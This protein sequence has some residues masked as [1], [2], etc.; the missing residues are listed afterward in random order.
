MPPLV[1]NFLNWSELGPKAQKEA[2]SRPSQRRDQSVIDTVAKIFDDL[3]REGLA[4]LNRWASRLDRHPYQRLDLDDSAVNKARSNLSYEALN[5]LELAHHNIKA[6]HEAELPMI[7]PVLS[8]ISGLKLQRHF[9]PIQTAGLY[10]PG[11]SAPLFSTLM[12]SALPALIA[13]VPNRVAITPPDQSGSLPAI[14]IAAAGLCG[15]KTIH[16]VGGAH[17]IAALA[18]GLLGAPPANKLFGPGNRYVTEAKR[19]A[20]ERYGIG[21]DLPAGPSELMVVCDNG[22]DLD[23]VVADLLSQAEHDPDAQVIALLIGNCDEKAFIKSLNDQI[24]SLPRREIA[25]ASLGQARFLRLET[26]DQAMDLINLYGP[27]HLSL[28]IKSPNHWIE[29]VHSAGTIFVGELSAETFG[30]YVNGPSHVLPTDGA[31]R[32]Y[33]GLRIT[34]FFKSFVTQEVNEPALMRLA[35]SAASL[36]RLEGLEAHARAADYRLN[37]KS[38]L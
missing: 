26:Y 35:P 1:P 31:A 11:G 28:Q 25:S 9:R 18:L 23:L 33:D 2:L 32:C 14:M 38:N 13:G 15:L 12:M 22:A 3:E 27:E 20:S 21:I 34:S 17:G 10:I 24:I 7:G 5:S 29:H 19:C 4:G 30:D 36:A 37:R 16:K 6:F 8:P